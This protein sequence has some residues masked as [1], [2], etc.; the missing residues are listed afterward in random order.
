M[1][2]KK[3]PNQIYSVVTRVNNREFLFSNDSV[4]ESYLEY[5]KTVKKQLK[6]KL[7]AFVIMSSHVHL[8]I[9]P[10]DKRADISKIM[11]HINGGFAQK[12]NLHKR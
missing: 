12:H 5:L 2:R 11:K 6:F 7:Y 9:E 1:P 10:D 3:L 4:A 8:L